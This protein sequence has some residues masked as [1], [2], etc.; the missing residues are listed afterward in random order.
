MEQC[1]I[2]RISNKLEAAEKDTQNNFPNTLKHT[3]Y[4]VS[5]AERRRDARIDGIPAAKI[6][7]FGRLEK[8]LP[9]D[10]FLDTT[11]GFVLASKACT[12]ALYLCQ[13]AGVHT[14]LGSDSGM[15]S[16]IKNG[17]KVI[18]L[19][20]SDGNSHHADLIIVACGGWTPSLVP[21][22]EDLVET[23]SGSVVSLRLPK[24]RQDL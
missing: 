6:D 19:I 9:I 4:R 22:I 23:T 16:L 12:F 8:G 11:A 18:G 3:Q 13:K 20:T 14:Y 21:E 17:N 2:L 1:G 7:P 5:D 15:K 10:G 24:D